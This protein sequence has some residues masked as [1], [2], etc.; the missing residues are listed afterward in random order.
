MP[1]HIG[2]VAGEMSGDILGAALIGAIRQSH[3]DAVFVGI[4]GPRMIEQGCR[5]LFPLEKL[6][7]MGLVEVLRHLPELLEIRRQLYRHF[8]ANHPDIFIGIDAPDFNLGLARRLKKSGIPTVHYVS[9]SVWAW[10]Q[11]RVRKIARSID[12]MLTLFP[13][14]ADFYRRHQVPVC[15]VGHPLADSI[16]QSVDKLAVRRSLGIPVA[17]PV[18]AL[19]PGSRRSELHYL[20]APFIEAAQWCL[21]RNQDLHFVVPLATPAIREIFEAQLAKQEAKLPIH[22]IDGQSHTVMAAAD[23]ILLASGTATLEAMLYKRPMVVAYKMAPLTYWLAKRLIRTPYYSLPN[24]LLGEA[25][26]EEVTQHEVTGERLGRSLLSLLEAGGGHAQ[27]SAFAGI[28]ER[29]GGNASQRAA[30]AVLSLL[31]ENSAAGSN[32]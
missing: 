22:L 28:A 1:L 3:P 20:A 23:V 14:E 17:H 30:N 11:Y 13:F 10:R 2:I 26:V 6:S 8:I 24:Q 19:L 21:T 12:L 32:L 31:A 9:P 15:F 29:L 4:G 25:C 5:S 27:L 16:P 18:I 7:V